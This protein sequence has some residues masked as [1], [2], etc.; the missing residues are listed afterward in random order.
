MICLCTLLSYQALSNSNMRSIPYSL[1][2]MAHGT[3]SHTHR[4][5]MLVE[6]SSVKTATL[7]HNWSL[8]WFES[9]WA[10]RK[11]GC[12]ED[13]TFVSYLFMSI[14]LEFMYSVKKI[15]S[16]VERNK[17]VFSKYFQWIFYHQEV[18]RKILIECNLQR[19]TSFIHWTHVLWWP[20]V[21]PTLFWA[22]EI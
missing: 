19:K 17:T 3:V 10:V 20:T 9:I 1:E 14:P 6:S 13:I 8:N 21:C 22:F 4:C 15:L 18:I 11:C 16:W 2:H 12:G 7:L 5:L